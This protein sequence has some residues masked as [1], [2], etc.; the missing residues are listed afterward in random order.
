[1]LIIPVRLQT[2]HPDQGLSDE[3]VSLTSQQQSS[4]GVSSYRS[5]TF[6]LQSFWEN[7]GVHDRLVGYSLEIPLFRIR[8]ICGQNRYIYL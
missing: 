4:L 3:A 1:M 8:S 5:L 2:S 7:G 6:V